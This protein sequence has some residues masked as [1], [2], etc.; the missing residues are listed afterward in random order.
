[1][2]MAVG[3]TIPAV[4]VKL[5]T[6]LG[7]KDIDFAQH[8]ATGLSVLFCVPAAFSTTCHNDHLPGYL[9]L[10]DQF[11]AKKVDRVACLSVNDHFV[12]SAWAQ[13]TGALGKIDM[14]ADGNGELAQAMQSEMDARGGGMGFRFARCAYIVKD[15]KIVR[16]FEETVRG[17]LAQTGAENLLSALDEL[18]AEQSV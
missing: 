16:A 4:S 17:S 9:A 8:V 13:Q 1:M 2:V 14:I 18:V 12:M 3:N 5:I 11:K 15:G 6:E 10:I 7:P